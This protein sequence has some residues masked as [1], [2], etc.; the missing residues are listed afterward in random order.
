M[1]TPDGGTR[2][3]LALEFIR[4]SVANLHSVTLIHDGEPAMPQLCLELAPTLRVPINVLYV[5]DTWDTNALDFAK[6]LVACTNGKFAASDIVASTM[7]ALQAGEQA[8]LML[9]DDTSKNNPIAL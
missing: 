4:D 8:R 9:V 1:P 6:E 3:D 7:L 2:L 5:G